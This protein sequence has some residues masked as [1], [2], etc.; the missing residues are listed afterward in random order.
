MSVQV[1][2]RGG[3]TAEH[4]KF[5]GAS[6]ELTI[7]TDK[8]T[9]VVHDG[10]T[11][12]GFPLAR[13]DLSNVGAQALF[14]N[15]GELLPS[16]LS[17]I[18]PT[19]IVW[20]YAGKIAPE[21]FLLYDGK[22]LGNEDSEA[23]YIGEKYKALYIHQWENLEAVEIIGGKGMAALADWDTGKKLKLPDARRR[24][25]VGA[26][27]SENVL[28]RLLGMV[29]G[30]E[31]QKLGL[32]QMPL[33]SHFTCGGNFVP[34]S[35][36]LPNNPVGSIAIHRGIAGGGLVNENYEYTIGP[37]AEE[38]YQG[39]TNNVGGSDPVNM[40]PPWLALNFIVKL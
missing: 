23:D 30:N 3:T 7:D 13:E 9:A 18:V 22:T 38:A 12:G 32:R 25:I 35:G 26:D 39:Q 4:K 8:K 19:G 29:G 10:K 11:K 6:R 1:Q 21:G 28:D 33:H 37:S 15:L 17:L 20:S 2:R 40:M 36:N 27:N 34:G 14:D 5:T 31:T 24:I 16:F